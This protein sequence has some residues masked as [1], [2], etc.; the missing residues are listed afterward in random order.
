M[1]V[2]GSLVLGFALPW[3]FLGVLNLSQ[4]VTPDAWQGRV[5]AAVMMALFAPQAPMQALG[6]LAIAHLSYR[7]LYLGTAATAVATAVWLALATRPGVPVDAPH[8][9]G[10]RTGHGD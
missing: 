4:R 9:P 5:S 8:F 2:L 7:S 6:A 10:A 1:A 3:V